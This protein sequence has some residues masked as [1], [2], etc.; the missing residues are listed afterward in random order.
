MWGKGM[1]MFAVGYIIISDSHF[2]QSHT[3]HSTISSHSTTHTISSHRSQLPRPAKKTRPLVERLNPTRKVPKTPRRNNPL[4]INDP[5]NPNR[6]IHIDGRINNGG[7][8]PWSSIF[9]FYEIIFIKEPITDELMIKKKKT[10][11]YRDKK[12]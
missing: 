12:I 5:V 8:K 6:Q 3:S 9:H 2:S 7:H 4:L 10:K 11:K 1:F